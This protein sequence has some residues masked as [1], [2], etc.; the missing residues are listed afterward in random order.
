MRAEE[1]CKRAQGR[2]RK[3]LETLT[4]ALLAATMRRMQ[5][6][7]FWKVVTADTTDMLGRLIALLEQSGTRF[8]VIDG[9]A[10]NAYVEP[11]VTLDLDLVI[12]GD[13]L[14]GIE[15]QLKA[16]RVE[17]FAHSVN[18]SAPGSDLRVQFQTDPRY[19]AFVER[20]ERRDVLGLSLPVAAVED[21]LQ[22]KLWA[23]QDPE[24][25][26]SKRQKDPADIARLIE[27]YQELRERVPAKVANRLL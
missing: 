8:C 3:R 25:R 15:T 16:F 20:A 13:D 23:V 6:W 27:R 1:P 18:I 7:A 17:R 26:A 5:P 2:V 24:R 19:Q 21:V 14:S 9:V 10:V 22:G 11:V 12:V 4:L